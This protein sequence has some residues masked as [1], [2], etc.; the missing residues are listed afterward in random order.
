MLGGFI[1]QEKCGTVRIFK[2]CLLILPF[3]T[4]KVDAF[5]GE[6]NATGL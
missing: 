5:L 1:F 4:R 6:W 3:K 2:H